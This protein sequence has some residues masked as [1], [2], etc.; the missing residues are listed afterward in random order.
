MR[1]KVFFRELLQA[2]KG[3]NYTTVKVPGRD[4]YV[5]DVSADPHTFNVLVKIPTS[6][7]K[8]PIIA[9]QAKMHRTP[10][11][12]AHRLEHYYLYHCKNGRVSHLQGHTEQDR[13]Q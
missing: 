6:N 8:L 4:A 12:K 11:E 5:V 9:G 3:R 7:P 13:V 10:P 2:H 1:D